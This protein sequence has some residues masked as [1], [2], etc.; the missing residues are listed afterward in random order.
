MYIRTIKTSLFMLF[1]LLLGLA[2]VDSAFVASQA[3]ILRVAPTGTD[4]NGCGTVDTPCLTLQYAID[5]AVTGDTIRVAAGTYTY[6]T[7]ND[8]C[9]EYLGFTG[10]VC[11]VNKEITLVGGYST[12]NWEISNPANN[13]TII[14]GQNTHRGV[15]IIDVG[16]KPTF[17]HIEGFTIRNGIAKGDPRPNMPYDLRIFAFGG[18]MYVNVARATVKNIIFE[19]NKSVGENTNTSYGG[20][21]SGGGLAILG[22]PNTRV[23][24]VTFRSNEARGGT[25]QDRGGLAIGGGFYTYASTVYATHITATNNLAV[26]G[27][28]NG[29]GYSAGEKGDAQGGGVAFQINSRITTDHVYI[30]NNQAIGGNAPNGDAGGAFGGGLF[31]EEASSLEMTVAVVRDNL[32]R[33]GT[34]NNTGTDATAMGGGI[35]VASSDVSIYRA[36]VVNNEARGGTG[37]KY[38]GSAG[39]GG[40]AFQRLVGYAPGKI[41]N[42]IIADNRAVMGSGPDNS[43]GGGGGGLFIQG[44]DVE[45]NHT[46]FARNSTGTANMQGTAVVILNWASDRPGAGKFNH[47]IIA[48]HT[49][50]A[51]AHAF[52]T[53]PNNAANLNYILWAGNT[54]D[55]FGP[56]NETNS[57]QAP[58]VN[59]VSPGAPNYDYHLKST[60]P[61]INAAVGSTMPIDIDGEERTGIR[62]I[63][64]DEYVPKIPAFSHFVVA[65]PAPETLSASWQTINVED[66]GHYRL[67]LTCTG[68]GA[69]AN[70]LPCGDFINTNTQTHYTLT[71]LTPNTIYTLHVEAYDSTNTLLTSSLPIQ[72]MPVENFSYL[73]L[74]TK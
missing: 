31:L 55:K 63:G 35:M 54:S 38:Q 71:G 7:Q 1:V 49:Q 65:P 59:F 9:V 51:S 21:G 57:I 64:A 33:G 46:T 40:V 2:V 4:D 23:E 58:T 44:A 32:S 61:A 16:D 14:D 11:V 28:T 15:Y 12:S 66:L 73:P 13:V 30:A 72:T 52:H 47:T 29:T 36:L 26:G 45:I 22:S 10:V 39:G 50:P 6:A 53:Q 70:E 41:E 3:N 19:N 34:G 48:D 62:D 27:S 69:P 24:H 67:Y 56:V 60:S 43:K 8:V 25:G 17:L 68:G 37:N 20:T 42:S 74:L 5:R 18:G